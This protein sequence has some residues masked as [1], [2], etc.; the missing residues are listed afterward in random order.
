MFCSP[1]IWNFLMEKQHS[2]LR[3]KRKE[4]RI[5]LL[6]CSLMSWKYCAKISSSKNAKPIN[7]FGL[8]KRCK[9]GN[10]TVLSYCFKNWRRVFK[11]AASFYNETDTSSSRMTHCWFFKLQNW[12]SLKAKFF[13]VG[14]FANSNNSIIDQ[15]NV[16]DI[17]VKKTINIGFLQKTCRNLFVN[18]IQFD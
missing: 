18:S 9:A 11:I 6:L 5:C 1:T 14:T 7:C 2:L 10:L 17:L 15:G 4:R 16:Q 3:S 8:A 12:N 13:F